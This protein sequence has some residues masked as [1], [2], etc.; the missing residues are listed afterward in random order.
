MTRRRQ[1][2]FQR[3][4]NAAL[5]TV[6]LPF[7]LPLALLAPTQFKLFRDRSGQSPFLFHS[8]IARREEGPWSLPNCGRGTMPSSWNYRLSAVEAE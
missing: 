1:S 3:L 2:I 6:M 5:V 8:I 4:K 7:V